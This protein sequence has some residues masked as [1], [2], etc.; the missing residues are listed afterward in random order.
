V[1][2]ERP[3]A[4][5][6]MRAEEFLP[7]VFDAR[8]VLAVEQFIERIRRHDRRI[9]LE[10]V[11]FAP[12]ANAH[13]RFELDKDLRRRPLGSEPGELDLR[14]AIDDGSRLVI[15]GGDLVGEHRAGGDGAE[16][17]DQ[18]TTVPHR[19]CSSRGECG[20]G[21]R[22]GAG[23]LRQPGGRGE[24]RRGAAPAAMIDARR[25]AGYIHVDQLSS[26]NAGHMR[27]IER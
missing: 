3:A 26:G 2:H 25:T 13:V 7:K 22:N 21:R 14:V 16:G 9:T 6:A 20:A 19:R 17:P 11:D 8:R 27:F 23:A 18:F 12:A 15:G 10:L 5:I 4:H 1:R 24:M